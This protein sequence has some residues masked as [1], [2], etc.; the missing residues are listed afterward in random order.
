MSNK[1]N[2]PITNPDLKRAMEAMHKASPYLLEQGFTLITV[3][4]L[5]D[6]VDWNDPSM[7]YEP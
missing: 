1:E 7:I 6:L 2:N 4:E 5:L 3:S